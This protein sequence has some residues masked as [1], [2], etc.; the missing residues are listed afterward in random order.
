MEHLF[1]IR[2]LVHYYDKPKVDH[3]AVRRLLSASGVDS[4]QLL[5][6]DARIL[7]LA[8]YIDIPPTR[9]KL[10]SDVAEFVGSSLV[11]V[12]SV[13]MLAEARAAADALSTSPHDLEAACSALERLLGCLVTAKPQLP[14]YDTTYSTRMKVGI[15]ARRRAILQ[16]PVSASTPT[17]DMDTYILKAVNA[18]L[19]LCDV[20]THCLAVVSRQAVSP[21]PVCKTAVNLSMRLLILAASLCE[22]QRVD[23]KNPALSFFSVNSLRT[24]LVSG[25]MYLGAISIEHLYIDPMPW[26]HV[27]NQIVATCSTSVPQRT[28][29]M[30]ALFGGMVHAA[31]AYATAE[32]DFKAAERVVRLVSTLHVI[33]EMNT[34]KNTRPSRPKA[35]SSSKSSSS[36]QDKPKLT[37]AAPGALLGSSPISKAARSFLGERVVAAEEDGDEGRIA[38]RTVYQACEDYVERAGESEGVL[39]LLVCLFGSAGQQCRNECCEETVVSL[40]DSPLNIACPPD[41]S[42]ASSDG[43]HRSPDTQQFPLD[44]FDHRLKDALGPSS[45]LASTTDD[46]ADISDIH[47]HVG[48]LLLGVIAHWIDRVHLIRRYD[49]LS[50]ADF[51]VQICHHAG[52]FSCGDSSTYYD[53]RLAMS[54]FGTLLGGIIERTFAA[55]PEVER[56]GKWKALISDLMCSCNKMNPIISTIISF[57]ESSTAVSPLL[58][59]FLHDG[60]FASSF[61]DKVSDD[62]KGLAPDNILLLILSMMSPDSAMEIV[63][64]TT[65]YLRHSTALDFHTLSTLSHFTACFIL[66]SCAISEIVGIK[67]LTQVAC[68]VLTGLYNQADGTLDPVFPSNFKLLEDGRM[69][70]PTTMSQE[71]A[72][73][74]FDEIKDIPPLLE[75]LCD[76]SEAL[77]NLTPASYNNNQP[78]AVHSYDVHSLKVQRVCYRV[79]WGFL[80]AQRALKVIELASGLKFSHVRPGTD[81]SLELSPYFFSTG[82]HDDVIREEMVDTLRHCEDST[83]VMYLSE[84]I[85]LTYMQTPMNTNASFL[86]L[87]LNSMIESALNIA[88]SALMGGSSAPELFQRLENA[89]K[90]NSKIGSLSYEKELVGEMNIPTNDNPSSILACTQLAMKYMRMSC[91]G[92]IPQLLMRVFKTAM[93]LLVFMSSNDL[94]NSKHLLLDALRV[95]LFLRDPFPGLSSCIF[96]FTK[97]YLSAAISIVDTECEMTS[98]I[99]F[100]ACVSGIAEAINSDPLSLTSLQTLCKFA[101]GTIEKPGTNNDALSVA[102]GVEN[103]PKSISVLMERIPLQMPHA[104]LEETVSCLLIPTDESAVAVSA[105]C[106]SLNTLTVT[107]ERSE[108]WRTSVLSAMESL[109]TPKDS[110]FAERMLRRSVLNSATLNEGIVVFFEKVIGSCKLSNFQNVL[111]R[112]FRA[113]CHLFAIETSAGLEGRSRL[114]Y[115][116]VKLATVCGATWS[117]EAANPRAQPLESELIETVL[118]SIGSTIQMLRE[119]GSSEHQKHALLF[120]C[121][122]LDCIREGLHENYTSV[123]S[124]PNVVSSFQ[125]KQK[126]ATGR[127]NDG[128][129]KTDGNSSDS[130]PTKGFSDGLSTKLE[131]PCKTPLCTYTSTG[132]Q[133]VE[134]HWYF[135]YTCDLAGSDGVCSV[136]ARVCHKNCEL[137]YSK[138]SRFFCDCGHGSDIQRTSSSGLPSSRDGNSDVLISRS[139]MVKASPRK[140]KPCLCLK[141]SNRSNPSVPSRPQLPPSQNIEPDAEPETLIADA[142]RNKLSSVLKNLRLS[143]S[144]KGLQRRF[145]LV[146]QTFK[147]KLMEAEI[148]RSL[149]DAALFLIED[150]EGSQARDDISCR[151]TSVSDCQAAL[152]NL[153]SSESYFSSAASGSK[154]RPVKILKNSSFDVGSHTSGEPTSSSSIPYGSMISLS[155]FKKIAAVANRSGAIEF[156]DVAETLLSGDSSSE[157]VISSLFGRTFVPFSINSLSFHQ[158]NSNI[159]LVLGKDK[160][161]VL[162]RL[163]KEEG[164]VWSQIDIEIGLSEYEGFEGTNNL[165]SASWVD[166][167][168]SLLLVVSEKFVKVFDVTVDTFCP[169]FF[170][171]VPLIGSPNLEKVGDPD[172]AA[173]LKFVSAQVVHPTWISTLK[174]VF[175]FVLV[176]SSDGTLFISRTRMNESMS[177]VFKKCFNVLSRTGTCGPVAPSG[178]HFDR[179]LSIVII[180]MENGDVFL[181]HLGLDYVNGTIKVRL[182]SAHVYR[183]ALPPGQSI[184]IVRSPG[185]LPTF[186]F[187]QKGIPLNSVGYFQVFPNRHVE[188]CSFHS[189]LSSAVL[190]LT[191]FSGVGALCDTPCRGAMILLE[192]GSIHKAQAGTECEWKNHTDASLITD[193]VSPRQR[194]FSKGNVGKYDVAD[195]FNPIPDAIGFFENTR[196]VPEHVS[197]TVLGE[198]QDSTKNPERMAVILAGESG[199][200]VSSTK[201]N[202]PFKF[203]ANINN[204]SLVI[205]GARIRFGGTERSRHRVP[206]EVKVFDRTVEL[207]CKNGLKRWIDIPFSVPE[208]TKNPQQV[209][210]QLIPRRPGPDNR[211]GTDGL[212]ALDCLEVHAVSDVEFTERKL[213]FESEKAKHAEAV[214]ARKDVLKRMHRRHHKQLFEGA[215]SPQ[216]TCFRPGQAALLSVLHALRFSNVM[217]IGTSKHL[218]AVANSLWRVSQEK[219]S[220][221]YR[222]FLQTLLMACIRLFN[223]DVRVKSA[224]SMKDLPLFG[225]IFAEGLCLSMR[226]DFALATQMKILPYVTTIESLLFNVGGLARI[227]LHSGVSKNFEP[228]AWYEMHDRMLNP[229]CEFDQLM[230]A[231]INL[232]RSGRSYYNSIFHACVGAVDIAFYRS[233]RELVRSKTHSS[234][235]GESQSYVSFLVEMLCGYDQ[236]LRLVTTERLLVLFD[237]IHGPSNFVGSPLESEIIATIHQTGSLES[238]DACMESDS[239][240]PESADET[241]GAQG[242]AYRCDSC[243]KVCDGEWWHCNDCEDFDL[244]T[245]CLRE[246]KEF[247]GTPH[248][249]THVMLRGT[250]EDCNDQN[251][252]DDFHEVPPFVMLTQELLRTLIDEVLELMKAGPSLTNWR[253]LDAAE[254]VAQLLGL[255]SPIELRAIRL[256]ALFDSKFLNTLRQEVDVFCN[257]LD[258]PFDGVDASLSTI[259]SSVETLLLF[260]RILM[261][262]RGTAM[263]AYIHRH[264]ISK[265]LV[266]V[267]TKIHYKLRL[268]VKEFVS[269]RSQCNRLDRSPNLLEE[270]VWNETIDGLHYALF[271]HKNNSRSSP[272]LWYTSN[273]L[274]RREC[275]FLSIAVETIRV[276]DYTYRSASSLAITDEMNDVPKNVLCDIMTFCNSASEHLEDPFLFKDVI[277]AARR[278]LATLT[279]DDEA[280]LNDII[281]TCLYREQDRRL[282]EALRDA[283]AENEMFSYEI[284]VEVVDVLKSLH[285]AASRHPA[286][287]IAFASTNNTI[288]YSI[289]R[290]SELFRDQTEVYALQ[291]LSAALASSVEL[292]SRAI[293]G[294]S[295]SDLG[296]FDVKDMKEGS[297]DFALSST[298]DKESLPNGGERTWSVRDLVETARHEKYQLNG[299][300]HDSASHVIEQLVKKVLLSSKNKKAR[301][302]ASQILMFALAGAASSEESDVVNAI[303]TALTNGL[304]IM[305]FSGV[306]ADGLMDILQFFISCCQRN[307]FRE[308]SAQHLSTLSVELMRLLNECFSSIVSHPNARVYC[309]LSEVL[310]LSGYYLESDPCPTCAAAPW[311]SAGRR[312]HR[313][314]TIRAETKYTDQSIMHRLLSSYEVFAI[315]VKV[316]DPRQTRRVK[317]IDVLYSTRI[318]SDATELKSPGHPWN[319]LKSIMLDPNSS[320]ATILLSLPVAISNVKFQFTEFYI[321]NDSQASEGSTSRSDPSNVIA[322][323]SASRHINRTG[324]TLQCPRCSRAVTDRHGICRNC[325]ENAYQCRQ[326]RNINYENLDGFLCNECG[327]CKHARFEFSINGRLT[328]VAE[329]VRNEDDR[330]RAAKTIEKETNN[331]HHCIDQL[332]RLRTS[333][334]RSLVYGSASDEPVNRS[335]LLSSTRVDLTDIL[336]SVSPKPSEIAVLE[337]LLEGRVNQE[338]EEAS[339]GT[340]GASIPDELTGEGGVST[341]VRDRNQPINRT[342]SNFTSP[343]NRPP[344]NET[345]SKTP[346]ATSGFSRTSSSLA[347][348]YLKDC[349]NV[350]GNMSRSICILTATRR[351]LVRYANQVG[352]NR[353]VHMKFAPKDERN[354]FESPDLCVDSS[355]ETGNGTNLSS[356]RCYSCLQSFIANCI[357]MIQWILQRNGVEA[358]L[359]KESTLTKDLLSIC[360]L[361]EI[362][363]IRENVRSV[364]SSLV[365]ENLHSTLLVCNE[366]ERKISFCIDSY[367]TV[368]AHSVARFEMSV[369]E[370]IAVLD[371]YCWEERLKLVVRILFKASVEALTCSAIAEGI[372]LPCLRVTLRLLQ[373]EPEAVLSEHNGSDFA[374]AFADVSTKAGL[375]RDMTEISETENDDIESAEQGDSLTQDG[376]EADV[377]RL[378]ALQSNLFGGFVH[379][380]YDVAGVLTHDISG[381]HRDVS[382]TD[383]RKLPVR[384]EADAVSS[385]RAPS[386]IGTALDGHISDEDMDVPHDR[387][388]ANLT[389]SQLKGALELDHDGKHVSA[390]IKKWLQG[391]QTHASWLC[392]M[393]DRVRDFDGNKSPNS[394][395]TSHIESSARLMLCKWKQLHGKGGAHGIDTSRCNEPLSNVLLIDKGN[396]IVRLMLITPCAAVRKEACALMKLLCSDE[397]MLHLQ[398]LDVLSGPSLPLGAEVGEKSEEFFDLL[399]SSLASRTYRL[400]LIGKGFLPRVANLILRKA[401]Q[402]IRHELY[403]ES[404]TSVVNFMEGYSLKRLVSLLRIT[405]DVI[406]FKKSSLRERILTRDDNKVVRCLQRSYL[407]L[408]KLI[409]LK[410]R[411]TDECASQL[412]EILLSKDFLFSGST[413]T[414]IVTACVSDLR[415]A[416]QRNDAQGVALLLDELCSMLCPERNEPTCLLT[417]NKAP[418]QE[419][420]IRGGMS[421][422]PYSSSSFDGPLMRDV[423]NKICKDLDLPGLLEDD[424]AMELLVA[425]NVVK[426][427]LPILAVYE[428]IWRRAAAAQVMNNPQP[429]NFSRSFGLRRVIQ[430]GISRPNVGFSP[431]DVP[432]PFLSHRSNSMDQEGP[433]DRARPELRSESPMVVVYRLSGLDGE[434]TEP[435]IDSLSADNGEEMSS[436]DLYQDT[437][438]LGEVGGFD[439]LFDL[440]AVVGSWGDDAET[441]VRAPALRLLRASCEVSQNRTKLAKSP[442]A[443]STL[444]DCAASAFE[445]AQGSP[446]AVTS[447]ESLL[448]AAER[449]LA[450]QRKDTE[451]QPNTRCDT[452]QLSSHDPD[453]VIARVEMFLERLAKAT[454]HTAEQSILHL[455]PFLIQG[456]KSAID[457]VLAK[458]SFS[459][460]DIDHTGVNRKKARQLSS[461]LFATPRDLRGNTFAAET[462]RAGVPSEALEYIQKKFPMPRKENNEAWDESLQEDGVPLA[463]RVMSGLCLF[464]GSDEGEAGSLLREIIDHQVNIV[465]VL[466]QLEMAVSDNSIGTCAE[467]LLEGLSCDKSIHLN[468][469]DTRNAIRL[470]RKEA[471]LASRALVLSEAGLEAFSGEDGNTLVKMSN[472]KHE[473]ADSNEKDEENVLLKMMDELPDEVGPACVVCGDGF[474]CRPEEALTIY[475]FCRKLPLEHACLGTDSE[476]ARARVSNDGSSSMV[477]VSV[478]RTIDRSEW[479]MWSGR[480]R[481]NS[482]NGPKLGSGSYFSSLTHMNAIHVGCHREAA[483]VDRS[484]RRDEWDGAALRNSQTKCNNLFPVRPPIC[485]MDPDE[486]NDSFTQKQANASFLTAVEGYF[487]RL[488]SQG[489]T[490]LSQLK[491]IMFD[492]GRS[493]LRFAD[494]GTVV[495]SEHTKGGGPHSNAALIPHFVQLSIFLMENNH[496]SGKNTNVNSDDTKV[497][498]L[499][500]ETQHVALRRYLEGDEIGDLTYYMALAVV[501]FSLD[502]W[503]EHVSVF[504]A[505]ALANESLKRS[506][507]LRLIA[508]VDVVNKALKRGMTIRDG[509]H[510]LIEF[511]RHIGLDE[512]FAEQFA[513]EVNHNWENYIRAIEEDDELSHA[514]ARNGDRSY[515]GNDEGSAL[516]AFQENL[517]ALR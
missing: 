250:G 485:L 294:Q 385:S 502:E 263:P 474:R 190:G 304:K 295:I 34:P 155:V 97:Q 69:D 102:L 309:R 484:S 477:G 348:T 31:K 327:Y 439:V 296:S 447:A 351:E 103:V 43:P 418:T 501:L 56:Q 15:T 428:Q 319:N 337:A 113:A 308:A 481:P 465:P 344:R 442:V 8:E 289:F 160:V 290:C 51:T 499:C 232:G 27:A 271:S 450:Q 196:V 291:L 517:E 112:C 379:S 136:C 33:L 121:S 323:S 194:R 301:R 214:K 115:F 372:I 389:V 20:A 496:E 59:M 267:L 380:N 216:G 371:D 292:A 281:D 503:L 434:A 141:S 172:D 29:V 370:A 470:A 24:A 229:Y 143:D 340:H 138:F 441:A 444:L 270:G 86:S 149:L 391:R 87:Q 94:N 375:L 331:V 313:L 368:D 464:L 498:K 6:S 178:M 505:R 257:Y 117:V 171:R 415:L 76:R 168:T 128:N 44:V 65:E 148:A 104:S 273:G 99:E 495:F 188:V 85:S 479:E 198:N 255:H 73:K 451:A 127:G 41:E 504:S 222:H 280:A 100:L 282:C 158:D 425:G 410:T 193:V 352:G 79:L 471:A 111:L 384:I 247:P 19:R 246:N 182:S 400:Y 230:R 268:F 339:Q 123:F 376:S 287:W 341:E 130:G 245:S 241:D 173:T 223:C 71:D 129:R 249:R 328:Y 88:R 446:A 93:R 298:A 468:I 322:G 205:V 406:P 39:G 106:Q 131:M 325:H 396:W 507:A 416:H 208:S 261:C 359:I 228:S 119:N 253:F 167:S 491:M 22:S 189:G 174:R 166:N 144:S 486:L 403:A 240:E 405:L 489:R 382:R 381:I 288:L 363:G 422:N 203:V 480:S 239:T 307:Y 124:I 432:H 460:D 215:D 4:L 181:A 7:S 146:E 221:P 427:D 40:S 177:P 452:V 497:D 55:L 163:M 399:E 147:A 202:E 72:R 390:D 311:E 469:Q 365:Y 388:W 493:F 345:A 70:I 120:L 153:A 11:Q 32:R 515:E 109:I 461:I 2:V 84:C 63:R 62:V 312:D 310:D 64:A 508:F 238:L 237:S 251:G 200:C 225:M 490:N 335:K 161:A 329:T 48:A 373:C 366:L 433:E 457:L 218:L 38:A 338:L 293:S 435:I 512:S 402:L 162:F 170:A 83:T 483:R 183:E 463:L 407:L 467:E 454:S 321:V 197:I 509:H 386:S 25:A 13:L 443:V 476:T 185:S 472:V 430:N 347:T 279:L 96:L 277:A 36:K 274:D 219:T 494:G 23:S 54:D 134:Q 440:L 259:P 387:L 332:G 378:H 126:C 355:C 377:S 421:R 306:L 394:S 356:S 248:F 473:T 342:G 90:A 453:E 514:L 409:S 336:D 45:F 419:E 17:A 455:L 226:R 436:E 5:L 77:S 431:V 318:V 122:L 411:L 278:L 101:A 199:E 244:C 234:N 74:I 164:P 317:R 262:A 176:L 256:E 260:L 350:Y 18:V 466:C 98:D 254:L 302:A 53:L 326:C 80:T 424:F 404:F 60:K 449:I 300:F 401:E 231:H 475:V 49:D 233:L 314:D 89:L 303:N 412:K 12:A 68:H 487:G 423:K 81:K 140:R 57:C 482:G 213:L 346:T 75:F 297:P 383:E 500:I 367:K 448:I 150:V 398:L 180:P 429:T 47:C 186:Y 426:L 354:S 364:I 46:T 139:S 357:Q 58:N 1:A 243:E 107:C 272:E 252:D 284:T 50:I 397:Q 184:E 374:P 417:L 152:D 265:L 392:D 353:L 488:A 408:Q 420:F 264:G 37:D 159:L 513:D 201:E 315:T 360:S 156:V 393:V 30:T 105:I 438:V 3:A 21:Y 125:S 14:L 16:L 9:R 320:E 212:V 52:L 413:V 478:R 217:N 145:E 165:L 78:A 61:P 258:T 132:D 204:K 333:I 209:T 67:G 414:T 142:L 26:V 330:K 334:I 110:D 157:K 175:Y 445:H 305:Q 456:M 192:D 10:I 224:Q 437:H 349:K 266:D 492:L 179:N 206:A 511:K 285:Q 154:V 195:L 369:L 510:W 358:H 82:L 242:W 316:I 66:F 35:D 133:Y 187:F 28:Y 191:P 210:F 211:H 276:L 151:W 299:F 462:V 95:S 42:D 91:S 283:I 275:V 236:Y 108:I 227:M 135:C 114:L 362:R 235:S 269:A 506:H 220:V 137:A 361:C 324:D 343:L 286:T 395:D 458:L 516:N 459:W 169:C 92:Q 116:A 207:S 118:S